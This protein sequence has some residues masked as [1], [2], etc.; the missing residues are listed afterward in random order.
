M[1]DESSSGDPADSDSQWRWA[2]G[3]VDASE[4]HLELW[5]QRE[6]NGEWA[7]VVL[8]SSPR[9]GL[10]NVSFLVDPYDRVNAK[11]VEGVTQELDFYLVEKGEPDPW[12]YAKYHCGTGANVYSFVHWCFFEESKA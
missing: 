2:E 6:P 7:P 8:V 3:D 4:E 5:A 11:I 9:Q 12:T 1:S 10:F